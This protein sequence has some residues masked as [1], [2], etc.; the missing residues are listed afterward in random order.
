V[1]AVTRIPY[2][3]LGLGQCLL[4]MRMAAIKFC[5]HER[6]Y[7]GTN[8][9]ELGKGFDD[10]SAVIGEPEAVNILEVNT[11]RLIFPYFVGVVA[12]A[13]IDAAVLLPFVRGIKEILQAMA[14]RCV[15]CRVER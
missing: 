8:V 10:I 7:I 2:G 1:V 12:L 4:D 15:G 3:A 9:M 14:D 5:L 13:V 6:N 11:E